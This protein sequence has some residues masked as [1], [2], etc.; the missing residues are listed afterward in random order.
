MASVTN[1]TSQF[2]QEPYTSAAVLPCCSTITSYVL[3]E[4]PA[5]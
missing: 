4:F 5:I 2:C 3:E 1:A